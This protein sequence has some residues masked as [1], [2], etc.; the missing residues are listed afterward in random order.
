MLVSFCQESIFK[1][2]RT[3][4]YLRRMGYGPT[5]TNSFRKNMENLA[6]FLNC[7]P[8]T[9][10]KRN[11]K[12]TGF[13][14]KFSILLEWL[15]TFPTWSPYLERCVYT[16]WKICTSF[17]IR[18]LCSRRTCSVLKIRC[19]CCELS[20]TFGPTRLCLGTFYKVSSGALLGL[21]QMA[22]VWTHFFTTLWNLH[23]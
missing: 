21:I 20:E 16:F 6:S 1:G 18:E 12:E 17:V 3:L 13:C 15:G 2:Y 5:T 4:P 11:V 10:V 23:V 19:Q 7:K 14:Q 9:D 22:C 8:L